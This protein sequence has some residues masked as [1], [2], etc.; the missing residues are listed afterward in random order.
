MSIQYDVTIGIPAYRAVKYIKDSLLSALDQSFPSIEFLVVD[1]CGNDG[2]MEV[3]YDLQKNH[4]RGRDIRILNNIVNHGVSYSRNRIIDEAKG[5]FLYFMDADDMIEPNT[6]QLLFDAVIHNQAQ[7]AYGSC[8]IIDTINN[9]STQVYQKE[10]KVL[11]GEDALATYAFKHNNIFHVSICN[12]LIDI[13]FLRKL[14]LQFMDVPFWED[15]AFTTELVTK[16]EKA[17][18]LSDITYHYIRHE[19]SLSHYYDREQLKKDE[20]MR[21]VS[22]LQYLKNMASKKLSKPYISFL[23]Y[24]L[25]MNSF[26]AVCYIFKK[27]H[28]ISPKITFKEM[29]SMLYHPFSVSIIIN[30]KGKCL[31]NLLFSFIGK[32]PISIFVPIIWLLG[33]YKKAI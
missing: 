2:T 32:L 8:E 26:Y 15:M 30:F 9:G 19:G 6:V 5:R 12:C 24:N 27:N 17:V 28:Q 21:N 11:T 4:L 3:V 20:I 25:E 13:A 14:K 18:L 33:K 23:C 10:S 16:V 29:R 7:V 1:D 22:V 31:T